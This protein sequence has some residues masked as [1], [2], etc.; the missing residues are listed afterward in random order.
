MQA[1]AVRF[2]GVLLLPENDAPYSLV[3]PCHDYTDRRPL[4]QQ[5]ALV[6]GFSDRRYWARTSCPNLSSRTSL[7][8]TSGSRGALGFRAKVGQK[9]GED[10]P[11]AK[12][13][14]PRFRGFSSS[15]GR[16]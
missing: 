1:A 5:K 9:S 2:P 14:K 15:G 6:Q 11:G 3:D 8:R 13:K 10:F 12:T 4:K 7:L 16:I